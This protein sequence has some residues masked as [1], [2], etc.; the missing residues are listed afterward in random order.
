MCVC[1][2]EEFEDGCGSLFLLSNV[3]FEDETQVLGLGGK[4]LH[5]RGTPDFL[6][7]F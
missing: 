3:G 1:A 4:H 5:P 7:T 6:S 2:R